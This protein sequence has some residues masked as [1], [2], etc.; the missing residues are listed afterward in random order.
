MAT[1]QISVTLSVIEAFDKLGVLY[2]IGG[3]LASTVHGV[4]R[5]TLDT[6]L[7]AQLQP[8]H[9]QPLVKMLQNEFYIDTDAVSNAISRQSSFN[10]IHLE[11]MFKVDV[12]VFRQRLFDQSQFA[13]RITQ[14]IATN[15]EQ[16]A[17]IASAEDTIL[18]KLEW[19]RMG[20][21]VSERQW[22]D[23]LGII[24]V[25]ENRLDLDYLQKWAIELNVADL[26]QRA[27]EV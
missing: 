21:E 10:L 8:E 2:L 19:Y 15:P 9:T 26:L 17:Y 25:Q 6:D 3:S 24:K 11:T 5:T 13:R 4:V 12:F 20:G 18:T 7:V 23:V 27:L 16:T 1:D 22:R 14:V